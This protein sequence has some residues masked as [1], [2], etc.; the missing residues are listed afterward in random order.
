M[1]RRN[2]SATEAA[3][4]AR[5]CIVVRDKTK[6]TPAWLQ[7]WMKRA[8]E[9]QQRVNVTVLVGYYEASQVHLYVAKMRGVSAGY[10]RQ[11]AD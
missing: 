1:K 5:S 7:E 4:P 3:S 11:C 6:S 10:P 8:R 9:V 2:A